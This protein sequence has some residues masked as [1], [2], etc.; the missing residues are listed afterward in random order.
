MAMSD[1]LSHRGMSK[2]ECCTPPNVYIPLQTLFAMLFLC[3]KVRDSLAES[4]C[5]RGRF[6]QLLS[7]NVVF[8][9][10]M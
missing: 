7:N 3:K 9:V 2:T 1:Q 4:N 5:R 10:V 8:N 6:L